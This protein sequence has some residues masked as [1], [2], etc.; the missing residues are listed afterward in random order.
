MKG[1]ILWD[2]IEREAR[3]KLGKGDDWELIRVEIFD[4]E[5]AK[6]GIR[7]PAMKN[8]VLTGLI[9]YARKEV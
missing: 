6:V 2:H 9:I 5:I 8:N 7:H 4:E 1:K 3:R